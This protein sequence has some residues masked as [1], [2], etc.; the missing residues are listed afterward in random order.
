MYKIDVL[1]LLER[2][3]LQ[4]PQD[5]GVAYLFGTEHERQKM[6]GID[7]NLDWPSRLQR[8]FLRS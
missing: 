5:I 2:L 6:A 3:R 8:L 7:G 4:V 1:E